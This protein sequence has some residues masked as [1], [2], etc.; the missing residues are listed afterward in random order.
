MYGV[1]WTHKLMKIIR[2]VLN[3]RQ[4]FDIVCKY[5]KS[6]MCVFH[7]TE[8]VQCRAVCGVFATPRPV[9]CIIHVANLF[10]VFSL[11]DVC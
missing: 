3:K 5:L 4:T 1:Q 11:S 8:G 2:Y 10:D 9:I 6:C 7:D